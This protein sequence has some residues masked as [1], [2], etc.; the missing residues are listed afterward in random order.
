[1]ATASKL[2]T[3]AWGR[4]YEEMGK[5]ISAQADQMYRTNGCK[6]G[7]YC[8]SWYYFRNAWMD[9][10]VYNLE[11]YQALESGYLPAQFEP[12]N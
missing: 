11:V 12:I 1:M 3:E 10:K 9:D 5:H 8:G 6:A 4:L 7:Q 2:S